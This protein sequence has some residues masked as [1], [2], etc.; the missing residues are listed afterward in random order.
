MLTVSYVVI[1]TII[2]AFI[3]RFLAFTVHHL[4]KI[5]MEES[6]DK[7]PSDIL[8]MFFQKPHCWHCESPISWLENLPIIGYFLLRGKCKECQQPLVKQLIFLEIGTAVL[9]GVTMALF[10]LTVPTLFVLISSCLLIGTF[11]TDFEHGILPDQFTLTLLWVGL[12][13][14]LFPVFVSSKQAILGAVFGYGFFWF[15]NSIYRYFRSLEGM[16]PGDFKLNAAIGACVGIQ[17]LTPIILISFLFLIIFAVIIY[18]F[19]TRK[20]NTSFLYQESPYGCYSSVITIGVLYLLLAKYESVLFK[21][22]LS[23]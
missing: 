9:F 19:R 20:I 10:P 11:L 22:L 15:M 21:G 18:I 14:S 4:P 6:E 3:G 13:G 2:G 5:L 8:K 17:W 16:Y 7:E 23:Q 12:I 1:A